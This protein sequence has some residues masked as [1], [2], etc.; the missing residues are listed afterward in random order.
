MNLQT[1]WM[2]AKLLIVSM[3][4]AALAEASASVDESQSSLNEVADQVQ[5]KGQN[6]Q[7]HFLKSD[8]ASYADYPAAPAF[9]PSPI[10][11]PIPASAYVSDPQD[12]TMGFV[13]YYLPTVEKY[14]PKIKDLIPY[15][16]SLKHYEPL[17]AKTWPSIRRV[18]DRTF[19]LGS[20]IGLA[21]LVPVMIVTSAG[22]LVFVVTLFLF[23]A[24]SAF[25]KRR[26]GRSVDDAVDFDRL[27]P[28][29]QSTAWADLAARV[30]LLVDSYARSLKSEG[31]MERLSCQAGQITNRLGKFTSPVIQFLEPLVPSY[32]YNKLTAFKSG[33]RSGSA[34]CSEFKCNLPFFKN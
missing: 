11:Q 12:T 30:D 21:L 8:T 9:H 17:M 31:C 25:G 13:Y 28:T 14:Y 4:V 5:I 22:F 33:A 32:M 20:V 2:L 34:D 24:L 27:V 7:S 29:E 23:P 18:A 1:K 6:R 3:A 19:D 26:L 16:K 10:P 15:L